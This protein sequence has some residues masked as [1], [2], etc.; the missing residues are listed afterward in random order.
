MI[1]ST[2]AMRNLARMPWVKVIILIREPISMVES[3][4]R[5]AV[6]WID[7]HG[8][9]IQILA[10]LQFSMLQII[11]FPHIPRERILFVPTE[12]LR[13]DP[14]L[15]SQ[16]IHQ[17]LGV[18]PVDNHVPFQSHKNP[19]D[20]SFCSLI[21]RCF[22]ICKDPPLLASIT[23]AV[24]P[25]LPSLEKLL[26]GDGWPRHLHGL[27]NIWPCT[28][29]HMSK[30]NHL[31]ISIGVRSGICD[32]MFTGNSACFKSAVECEECC[33]KREGQC[34]EYTGYWQRCCL[35]MQVDWL[36]RALKSLRRPCWRGPCCI[37]TGNLA[38]AI[39]P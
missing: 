39:T 19:W 9:A 1:F 31:D 34:A 3:W 22:N 16:R 38:L 17:F 24:Q 36:E 6:D 14:F 2:A 7:P 27:Q 12:A 11:V 30:S 28:R 18:D 25:E 35:K 23:I 29:S 20:S 8:D 13:R 5:H 10:A 15:A 26:D 33:L 4:I 37:G 21:D 32:P